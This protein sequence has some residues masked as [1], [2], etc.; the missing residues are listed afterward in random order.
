MSMYISLYEYNSWQ[1]LYILLFHFD[2]YNNDDYEYFI[3]MYM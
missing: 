1:K 3:T 2:V